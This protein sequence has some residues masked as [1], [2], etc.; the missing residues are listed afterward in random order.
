MVLQVHK[1]F[2]QYTGDKTFKADPRSKTKGIDTKSLASKFAKSLILQMDQSCIKSSKKFIKY[3]YSPVK[4]MPYYTGQQDM[5]MNTTWCI[6]IY[7]VTD[8]CK[9]LLVEIY[10]KSLW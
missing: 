8:I 2:Y 4:I 9:E 3:G 5:T 7:L 6:K 1:E 10:Y